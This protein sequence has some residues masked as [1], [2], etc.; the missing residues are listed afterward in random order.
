MKPQFSKIIA[1]LLLLSSSFLLS[2]QDDTR[3]KDFW[4]T[5]GRNEVSTDFPNAEINLQIRIVGS[6]LA[7]TGTIH[8]TDLGTA[9]PFSI[10]AGQVYTYNLSNIEKQAA[11]CNGTQGISNFSVHITSSE[12]VTVYALNQSYR[13]TDATNVLPVTA[14]GIDYYQ[15]SYTVASITSPYYDAYAVIAA[16][17]STQVYHNGIL[18]ATLLYAGQVYYRTNYTDMT[19][20]HITT[21]KPAA[22]FALHQG[23]Q[24]PNGTPFVDILFQ[25]LAPVNTWGRTFFVPVSW[26][27]KDFVRIVASQ[28]G[29]N[30]TQIGGTIRNVWG[31]QT[32]LTNLNAGQWVELE[33]SLANNGCYIQSDKPI[34]VCAYLTGTTYNHPS[35]EL[36]DPAQAW[37]P[38][39]EQKIT[40]GLIA[41]F[42][43][44]VLTNLTEHYAL[45]I[46]PTATKNNTT[47]KIGT[48]A[49]KSLSGGTWYDNAAAGMSFY[50][51]PLTNSTSAYLF[52]N[53]DDGLIIMG[54]GTGVAESYYYL[55]SSGMRTLDATF[56]ANDI[57]YQ[58]LSSEIICMQPVQFRSE[59]KGDIS[60]DTGHLKWY[61]DNV[62]E[63]SARDQFSWNK[64]FQK[65]KYQIKMEAI[66]E[67]DIMK[68]TVEGTLVI[69]SVEITN[70]NGK[71]MICVGD[72]VFLDG[73]PMGGDWKS[74]SS[75]TATV[76][77]NG[78]V[79]GV[80]AGMAEIRYV[81]NS[82]GCKDSANTAIKIT[83][84][85]VDAVT[86]PEICSRE[87]ATITL[88]VNHSEAP[89]T[90]TYSWDGRTDITPSL[91]NIKA[92]TY[93]ATISDSF[94]IVEKTIIVE[95]IDAPV[96]D[97]E[98]P[99]N[100]VKGQTFF[101]TDLSK[102]TVQTWN[103]DMG[104][105]NT[106]T[107]KSI[108]HIYPKEGDYRIFLE[109]IDINNCTDSISKMI[110]IY[111]ELRVFIP[112]TFTPNG[113]GINDMWKPVMLDYSTKGYELSVFD[114]WGQRIF[115][116]TDTEE[117]W[118]GTT[119]GKE[120]AP[121]AVYSYQVR[122]KDISEKEFKFSGSI[123][124][125]K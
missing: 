5:F 53:V 115:H 54:Y 99:T 26:R 109:V 17:D 27:G 118:D 116:T 60:T 123:T 72:I 42:V 73:T 67:N 59:I 88:T 112:N 44:T 113:D 107:G 83:L 97:F 95:H 108:S 35:D 36:S 85:T 122:V 77:T 79:T 105:G 71:T 49:Y 18:A 13:T 104:D 89:N 87:N 52:T 30:I 12:P 46:T 57:H 68:K 43:P 24:I 1:S 45:I 55:S 121:N 86:T 16:Q 41:P 19:G 40:T 98:F 10:A 3:G 14:F 25:Q 39:I 29:T 101:I 7:T 92:G 8:F 94:C 90:I 110:H 75:S 4:L 96:A 11:S 62:E 20:S 47:V 125:V 120:A 84:P 76:N 31:G 102:G 70:I 23:P 34:G 117:A 28:N 32:T 69:D 61:I 56:F 82:T 63:I 66:M 91:S 65:G 119:N 80:S 111:D 50:S 114:R 21:D 37:L 48:G 124:L 51:Y 103:W 15:L 106:Q 93:K 33:V 74:V 58:N 6:E 9:V 78:V 81:Y 2:A 64:T 22:F 38:S 100:V